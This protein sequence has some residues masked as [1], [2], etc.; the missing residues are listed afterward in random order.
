MRSYRFFQLLCEDDA[1]DAAIAVSTPTLYVYVTNPVGYVLPFS[2]LSTIV[3][4]STVGTPTNLGFEVQVFG[5]T[6]IRLGNLTGVPGSLLSNNGST[7]S[8][9]F[10]LNSGIYSGVQ[11]AVSNT[12]VGTATG[13]IQFN[14]GAPGSPYRLNLISIVN[15]SPP[16]PQQRRM[17]TPWY[18]N[19]VFRG[20]GGS[21]VNSVPDGEE[22]DF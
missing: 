1:D 19:I 4:T 10:L 7:W 15:N 17:R 16:L 3:I 2:S 21:V 18:S 11:F 12:A 6:G 20:G 5:G 8:S 13:F 14:Y 22:I 9:G